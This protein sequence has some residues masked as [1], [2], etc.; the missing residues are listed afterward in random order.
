MG[1]ATKRNTYDDSLYANNCLPWTSSAPWGDTE[2]DLIVDASTATPGTSN[3]V[4][5]STSLD[6]LGNL[7]ASAP[8]APA[9]SSSASLEIDPAPAATA[10]ITM[11]SSLVS[12]NAANS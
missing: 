2:V 8:G 11:G 4:T 9:D 1:R 12:G 7:F 3:T 6:S 10:Q 5:L